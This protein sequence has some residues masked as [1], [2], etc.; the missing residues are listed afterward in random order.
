MN[1]ATLTAACRI[2]F[3]PP[4]PLARIDKRLPALL[5]RRKIKGSLT[6]DFQLL[7]FSQISSPM[8]LNTIGA[9]L[10]FYKNFLKTFILRF[11]QADIHPTVLSP[12]IN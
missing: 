3:H 1:E 10:N 9:I 6:G 11:R 7:I 8:N 12:A 5:R 2:L 4:S